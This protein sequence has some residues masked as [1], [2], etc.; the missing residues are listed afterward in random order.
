MSWQNFRAKEPGP[1]AR[2][3]RPGR[4]LAAASLAAMAGLAFP[5][6]FAHASEAVPVRCSA[7][8]LVQAINTANSRPGPDTLR[9]TRKCT[10]KLTASDPG[11]AANGLPAITS[12]ITI[13]GNGATITRD[14]SAP[15]FR[16]LFVEST[17]TLTLNKT[18][19]S[20]GRATDCPGFPGRGF[21]CGGGINNQ[22]TLTVN[23]SR[24]IDNTAASG[25]F[26]EGGGIDS[27]GTATLNNTEVSGN[28]AEYTGTDTSDAAGGGI[29]NDGPLTVN[30]GYVHHNTVRVTKDTHSTATGSGI[31]T[32]AQTTIRYSLISHNRA[33]A[34]GGAT[35][36]ALSNGAPGTVTDT[37][38]RDNTSSAPG[39]DALGGGVATNDLLS[40]TRTQV[41]GNLATGAGMVRAGGIQVGRFGDLRLNSSTV[42][43][44]SATATN[45]GTAQGGGLANATGGTITSDRSKIRDNTARASSGGTAEGGGVFT[46]VGSTTL[47]HSSVIDNRAGDGGGIFKASGTVTLNDTE[48]KRN[49]PNNCAPPGSVPGCTG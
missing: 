8:A 31:A 2:R 13:D 1:G 36:A 45:G 42:G 12:E 40:M 29:A 17:G 49:H 11:N 23:H 25:V 32:F 46:A 37:V 27:D 3:R 10:Y 28:N 9:L 38:I 5:A 14:K 24:V 48:V 21:V 7:R 19:I 26:A 47:N 15:H 39:G 44:N 41:I 18:T 43:G 33:S 16:I 34:P 4:L 20:R 30:H 35:L 22:G 6:P